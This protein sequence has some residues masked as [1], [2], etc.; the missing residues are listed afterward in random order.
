M[1]NLLLELVYIYF[2]LVTMD[3]VPQESGSSNSNPAGGSA[4]GKNQEGVPSLS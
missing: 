1:A 4:W 2:L 3:E